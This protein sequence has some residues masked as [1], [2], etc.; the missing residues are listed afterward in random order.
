MTA[1]KI[2]EGAEAASWIAERSGIEVD[3][4]ARDAVEP[5]I[6]AVRERGDAALRELTERFDGVR[7]ALADLAP[8][9][10]GALEHARQNIERFH[11]AQLRTEQAVE[12]RPGVS[13]WREFRPIERVGVYVPGGRAS[14]PSSV[15]MCG[16]PAQLAG[17]TDIVVC[18]PPGP[19]GRAPSAVLAAAALLGIDQVFAV[20]GAQA[21]AA[22]AFGTE[23]VP[24]WTISSGPATA[25]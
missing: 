19:D 4:T 20:G 11:H 18:V 6:A 21:I 15:L 14:Y 1:M 9:L 10:R 2:L 3:S 16:I 22:M 24:G 5:I 8:E 7:V 17:C 12:V 23:S 25:T 13:V